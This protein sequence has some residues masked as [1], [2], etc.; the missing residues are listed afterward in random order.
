MD[1][2]RL[3]AFII[4]GI[5]VGVLGAAAGLWAL[6]EFAEWI[7]RQDT[8]AFILGGGL[9]GGFIAAIIYVVREG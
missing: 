8:L 7:L 6:R 1:G 9:I 5:V 3:R 4:V 2:G